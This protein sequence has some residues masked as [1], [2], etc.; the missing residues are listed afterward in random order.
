MESP[1]VCHPIS[2]KSFEDLP[3]KRGREKKANDAHFH[4]TA[5]AGKMCFSQGG[6]GINTYYNMVELGKSHPYFSCIGP[7]NIFV[8]L[9]V[10]T[11]QPT[12]LCHPESINSHDASVVSFSLILSAHQFN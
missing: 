1:L 2:C 4:L 6:G 7:M 8:F 3:E 10:D 12:A 9:S 11:H 5:G